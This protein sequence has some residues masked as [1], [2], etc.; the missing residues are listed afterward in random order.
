MPGK[1]I[2]QLSTTQLT[3]LAIALC[4]PAFLIN[5]GVIAF[6]G[7]EGI[8]SLV[9]F[10]MWTS[11]DYIMPTLNGKPYYNK[12]PL[13]NWIILTMS[14]LFGYFGEWPARTTT[15]LCLTG[16][17]ANVYAITRRHTDRLT[18]LTLSLMLLTSGRI[19]FWDSMLGLIDIGFSWVIWLNIMLLYE[20][21][22]K[23]KWQQLFLWSY[24]LFSAAFMLKGLPAVVFQ[25]IS[26]LAALWFHGELKKRFFSKA[27]FLGIAVGIMP[28]VIYYIAYARQIDLS[29]VMAVLTDQ[30]MQRTATHHGIGATVLHLFT[31]PFEQIYHF[32][33]WSLVAVMAFHPKARTWLRDDAFM[34]YNFVLL[35][36]NIPVYWLSVEVYPRYLLMFVP[37]FNLV[38]Y[39][40]LQNT[41]AKNALWWNSFRWLFIIMVAGALVATLLMPIDERVRSLPGIWW[42]SFSGALALGIGLTALITDRNRIFLWFALALLVV[43]IIFNLVVLPLRAEDYREN[44]CRADCHRLAQQHGDRPW[45]LY[46][47]T[48]THE[49]ARFYTAAYTGRIITRATD[50]TDP[51]AYYL[52]DP[53]RYPDVQATVIDSLLLENR[54]RLWL[55]R[56]GEE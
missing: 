54:S 34:R 47:D 41:R 15:L 55:V 30:S 39:R 12:P 25:V 17:A 29:T 4:L 24:L 7:D 49:V 22:R 32:L 1:Y 16:Y 6:I 50:L 42:I 52:I 53:N 43:R 35:L 56:P 11:G 28:L 21:P 9:A 31:F 51:N 48:Y 26:V 38:G 33:P 8:R 10:E 14:R 40:L 45:Y 20:L 5:L 44:R 36:A 37:L 19:L 18:A 46:Q 27:H 23:Q 3:L 2:K 13:Y